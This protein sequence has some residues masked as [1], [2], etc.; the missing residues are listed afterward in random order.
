MVLTNEE[1]EFNL[2]LIKRLKYQNVLFTNDEGCVYGYSC[3]NARFSVL[4]L[5]RA[6]CFLNKIR[7]S[8]YYDDCF[9]AFEIYGL[10]NRIIFRTLDDKKT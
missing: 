3:Q 8:I 10:K 2:S 1:N 6:Y 9:T 7:F 5:L 4:E